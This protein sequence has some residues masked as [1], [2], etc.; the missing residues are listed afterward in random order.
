M[1]S[2]PFETQNE[3]ETL[4]AS[5]LAGRVQA[6]EKEKHARSCYEFATVIRK[7]DPESP[8]STKYFAKGCELKDGASCFNISEQYNASGDNENAEL[9]SGKAVTNFSEA[10]ISGDAAS[11]I[12]AGSLSAIR[13]TLVAA[14]LYFS[15]ACAL[16]IGAGCARLAVLPDTPAAEAEENLKLACQKG[17]GYGCYAISK[18]PA[19]PAAESEELLYKSCFSNDGY[20]KGCIEFG[21]S[22]ANSNPEAALQAYSRGC[23]DLNDSEACAHGKALAPRFNN[24]RVDKIL[25]DLSNKQ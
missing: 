14:R 6:C 19:L 18:N 5:Y 7:L 25:S 1:Q 13:G 12:K 3:Q 4:L 8:L 15:R 17:S 23:V 10:C 11:C 2:T 22:K 24:Y 16:G 9:Y 20:S 21:S